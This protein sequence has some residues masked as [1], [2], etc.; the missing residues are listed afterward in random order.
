MAA[1]RNRFFSATSAGEKKQYSRL[2]RS[3]AIVSAKAGAKVLNIWTVPNKPP[4]IIFGIAAVRNERR[5]GR[6]ANFMWASAMDELK[7]GRNPGRSVI[8]F[9]E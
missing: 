5:N 9:D 1:A 4:T 7:I 8:S 2:Y 6:E 3:A